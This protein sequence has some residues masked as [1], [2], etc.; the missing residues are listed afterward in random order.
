[1]R[2]GDLLLFFAEETNI[3]KPKYV[4]ESLPL[5]WVCVIKISSKEVLSSL[6]AACVQR[7]WVL[8][9]VPCL[10]TLLFGSNSRDTRSV[11][12]MFLSGLMVVS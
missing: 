6:S 4:Q 10:M 12:L 8:D 11:T 2:G 7:T 5:S 9:L 1:M 3:R